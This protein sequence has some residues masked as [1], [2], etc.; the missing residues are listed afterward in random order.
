M[1]QQKYSE[2][3]ATFQELQRLAPES[4]YVNGTLA[5]LNAIRQQEEIGKQQQMQAQAKFDEGLV[6]FQKKQF[7]DAGARFREAQ[8]LNPGN[9][10]AA[11]YVKLAQQEEQKALAK[12]RKTATKAPATT[13]AV[14][15]DTT[16]S[17]P[18]P[19]TTSASAQLTTVFAHPFTDGRIVVRLGGDIVANERLYDERPARFLRRASRAARPINVTREFPAK[20]ADVQVWVTVPAAQIQEHRTL[21]AKRFEP[22][23][24][25][26]LVVRYDAASKN[27]TYE[28]E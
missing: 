2:A 5:R 28:L 7:A 23:S 20:N 26:R 19:V 27:F 18:A 15:T 13:T 25:H 3:Y 24:Q 11:E 16:A 10:Q 22:G 8:T 17:A 14:A 4:P 1:Q 21:P 12:L 6:L 9:A